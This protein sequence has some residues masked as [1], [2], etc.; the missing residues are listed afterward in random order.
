M[1][2]KSKKSPHYSA[3]VAISFF[4]STISGG[5]MTEVLKMWFSDKDEQK[6]KILSP[7]PN[8]LNQKLP[9]AQ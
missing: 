8:P 7:T 2:I 6:W 4:F 1:K 3:K 9:V 5:F